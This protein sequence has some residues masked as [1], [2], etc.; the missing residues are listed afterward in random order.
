MTDR[1]HITP[2]ANM[3]IQHLHTEYTRWTEQ[4]MVAQP[5]LQVKLLFNVE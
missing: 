2:T 5:M 1:I 4:I 3:T